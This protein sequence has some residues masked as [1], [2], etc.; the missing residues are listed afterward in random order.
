MLVASA[1]HSMSIVADD[2]HSARESSWLQTSFLVDVTPDGSA[3]AFWENGENGFDLYYR[4]MNGEPTKLL[5]NEREMPAGRF[6]PDG[7]R[8]AI[9]SGRELKIVPVESGHP[10][11]ISTVTRAPAWFQDNRRLVVW[12]SEER[13]AHPAIV[14]TEHS[15]NEQVL[16]DMT[17]TDYPTVSRRNVI[18]CLSAEGLQLRRPDG[19][20]ERIKLTGVTPGLAMGWSD[21]D[22]ALYSYA[23]GSVP[24]RV[25]RIDVM[26]GIVTTFRELRMPDRSGV[27][28]I[29]PV[30]PARNGQMFVYSADQRLDDLYIYQKSGSGE[31]YER[32]TVSTPATRTTN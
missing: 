28:N 13:D 3:S 11:T 14:D 27:W 1:R 8:L 4:R 29:N 17:C 7:S 10:Q 25:N 6:S 26:T 21:D 24:M 18:A 2:S 5:E 32:V 31:P 12:H 19:R 23:R 9:P 30:R 20:T 16:S 22:R 15:G